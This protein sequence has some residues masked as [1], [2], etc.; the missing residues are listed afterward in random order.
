MADFDVAFPEGRRFDDRQLRSEDDGRDFESF[1]YEALSLLVDV[2]TLRPGFG[3]GRDGAIDH[4]IEGT[5][6]RTVIECKFIGR[7]TDGT[8]RDRWGEVRRNL[9]EHLP[10]LAAKAPSARSGSPYAPWLDSG[11]R[12]GGYQF[13]VSYVFAH[14]EERNVLEKQ[15][16]D[17]LLRLAQQHPDLA[18]LAQIHVLVRG[19]DDFHGELRRRF[20]LRYRWFGD[21][22]RGIAPLRDTK[23]EARSFRRFLFEETLPFF[24]RADYLAAHAGQQIA[25]EDQLVSNLARASGGD[26]ALIVTGAGGVGKT[27]LGFELCERLSKLGWLALRLTDNATSASIRELI[28]S[29]AEPAQIALLSDYAERADDLS[30]IA[31]EIALVNDG[32]A[33]RIRVIATCRN[34]ATSVVE[35][36]LAS[37]SPRKMTLGTP[38]ESEPVE[39]AFAEWVV[40]RIL[41]FGGVPDAEQIASV[42]HGLPILAAFALFLHQRDAAQFTRQFGDLSSIRG[43]RDWSRQRLNNVAHGQFVG[44]DER[45]VFRRLALISLSLPMAKAD[46]DRLPTSPRWTAR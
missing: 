4:M 5:Q 34:S 21:L 31:E 43:F 18:H 20:P 19:W 7:T 36:T 29:H 33:H 3:R 26:D 16:A 8:P 24:S 30:A 1:V 12:I 45:E 44:H 41:E 17:D 27:R 22:P 35:D 32:G 46:A 25:R 39:V 11:Y 10:R 13:C 9:N 40:R 42:C 6:D 15:I 28:A 23:F 37:L 2:E 38:R 14:T